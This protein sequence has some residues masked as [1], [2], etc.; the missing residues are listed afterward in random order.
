MT[1]SYDV[2]P[3]RIDPA[4]EFCQ[5]FGNKEISYAPR[6]SL[7]HALTHGYDGQSEATKKS[8]A[9]LSFSN[10]TNAM[11]A[12][13]RTR[14]ANSLFSTTFVISVLTVAAGQ[15]LP[16]PVPNTVGADSASSEKSNQDKK[17]VIASRQ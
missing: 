3:P 8:N 4:V 16:C 7:S 9:L 10:Q 6:P 14:L 15:L 5:I 1:R 2:L 11:R 17:I 13:Q 12:A